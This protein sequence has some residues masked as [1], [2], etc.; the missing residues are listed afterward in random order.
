MITN[1]ATIGNFQLQSRNYLEFT[2]CCLIIY[3]LSEDAGTITMH[4]EY[5]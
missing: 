3:K 4:N 5:I 2:H 1:K